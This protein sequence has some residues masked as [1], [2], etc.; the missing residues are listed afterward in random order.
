M[1]TSDKIILENLDEIEKDIKEK[2]IYVRKHTIFSNN[3]SKDQQQQ[4]SKMSFQ[5][6]GINKKAQQE[7][8]NWEKVS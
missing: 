7:I 6:V 4:Q 2:K 1:K 8:G 3:K 5:N